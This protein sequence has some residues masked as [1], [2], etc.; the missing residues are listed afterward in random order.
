MTTN[1][2]GVTLHHGMIRTG[3][4]TNTG[5][6]G[7]V[8][9]SN[10]EKLQ[11]ERGALV[12]TL[13]KA[14]SVIA[15]LLSLKDAGF[16]QVDQ[17]TTAELLTIKKEIDGVIFQ[18]TPY[19]RRRIAWELERTAMSDGHYGDALRAAKALPEVTEEDLSLLD[20]YAAGEQ[21]GTDHV[22]LQDLAMKISR[23]G[24]ES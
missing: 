9:L 14:N 24:E 10:Y 23:T 22:A 11:A 5:P 2:Q 13:K 8:H 15:L 20:R 4:F 6:D 3:T 7:Y 16:Y 19:N 17:Q 18:S 12:E 21:S 1:K